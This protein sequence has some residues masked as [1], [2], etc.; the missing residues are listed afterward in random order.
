MN[1]HHNYCWR[2][3]KERIFVRSWEE[4]IG[5]S[6]IVTTEMACPDIECQKLVEKANK[7]TV[8]KFKA[9]R[10]KRKQSLSR[11][12]KNRKN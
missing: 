2:C 1:Q 4:K 11:N 9:S 6:I 10:L 12:G 8:D 7:K 3:G 5:N